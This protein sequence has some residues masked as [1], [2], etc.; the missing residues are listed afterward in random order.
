MAPEMLLIFFATNPAVN[1]LKTKTI[2]R[3]AHMTWRMV[4][5]DGPSGRIVATIKAFTPE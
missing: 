4:V 2:S 5:D 3:P 1:T